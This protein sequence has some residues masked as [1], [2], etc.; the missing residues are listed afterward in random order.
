MREALRSRF[1]NYFLRKGNRDVAA[2]RQNIQSIFAEMDATDFDEALRRER[3]RNFMHFVNDLD[4]SRG[5]SFKAIASEM[6][7]EFISY[8]GHWDMGTRYA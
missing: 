7:D 1:D 5:L 8:Y 4:K 2:V 3:M 6:Y